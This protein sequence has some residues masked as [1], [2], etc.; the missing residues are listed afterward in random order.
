MNNIVAGAFAGV[1]VATVV[2]AMYRIN[3]FVLKS[4]LGF[5]LLVADAALGVILPP[6]TTPKPTPK[7]KEEQEEE[8]L[9]QEL[10]LMSREHER[11]KEAEKEKRIL[12]KHQIA[13]AR[14]AVK[15]ELK[16]KFVN[17]N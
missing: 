1:A 5:N 15:K 3:K 17:K 16:A 13:K 6:K 11:E 8:E 2:S 9:L 12:E 4:L 7:S 14:L 10:I